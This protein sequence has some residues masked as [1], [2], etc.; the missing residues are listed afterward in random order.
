MEVEIVF[1]SEISIQSVFLF[2][3]KQE[4]SYAS[5]LRITDLGYCFGEATSCFPLWSWSLRCGDL[6][7]GHTHT[8]PCTRTH[9]CVHV[10][11][12]TETCIHPCTHGHRASMHRCTCIHVHMCTDTCTHTGTHGHVIPICTH[13]DL[14]SCGSC[15]CGPCTC[16]R[17]G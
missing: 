13:T 14:S 4:A 2:P 12:C 1:F 6:T 3:D 15:W 5:C 7:P 16:G 10:H 8:H 17:R 11:T 9:T